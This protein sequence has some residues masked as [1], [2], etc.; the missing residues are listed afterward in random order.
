MSTQNV[1]MNTTIKA[2]EDLYTSAFQYH[3]IALVDGLLAN[4]G[5]EA[6]GILLN[7][8]KSGEFLTLGYA[9]E[10]KFAAGGAISKGDKV[11][12][13]TSGWFTTAD[14]NDP[15]LGEAKAAVTSGSLGTGLF[16]F[17]V[18]T[19]KAS[20]IVASFTPAVDMI[21]GTAIHL[22][23]DM[24]Q[25][26]VSQE[27]DA[28]A[29]AAA[30]SGTA[31][32]FGVFGIMDVRIDPAQVCSLGDSLMVTTS[33]YFTPADSGYWASAKAYANIGSDATGSALFLGGHLSYVSSM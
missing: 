10:M 4:N 18:G 28:V 17:P 12:V 25:A 14:S 29:I 30:T 15:V 20:M 1:R 9:G 16:N 7:K 24:L 8:P 32:N 23:A 11:T 6:S 19:D 13:T 31:Q 27:A 3:A 22:D 21:A 33:G 26:D 2:E 5:E